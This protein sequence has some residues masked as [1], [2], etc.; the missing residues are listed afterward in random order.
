MGIFAVYKP[1]GMTSP[2]V[3]QAVRHATGERR[4]GHAG[5]LDPLAEGVLVVGVGRESTRLLASVVAHE[6]EYRALV[7][8]GAPSP[9]EDREGE[10]FAREVPASPARS[11]VEEACARFV[12]EIAQVPSAYSAVKV[13][14]KEAYKRARR[15]EAFV[16]GPRRVLIK[17]ITVL[18]YA[19]PELELLVTTG[20]G[21]YIR[22]LARD[23]GEA[24]GT[25]AYLGGLVRTRVGEYRAEDAVRVGEL[26]RSG[27]VR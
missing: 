12:G 21:V 20:P 10:K 9:T 8:L 26:G 6:K 15:G 7:I 18:R 24:L 3:V 14:G 22:A 1:I 27:G 4:V 11:V 2:D 5:T 17:S 25:G 13:H 19:Y 16:L 23:I